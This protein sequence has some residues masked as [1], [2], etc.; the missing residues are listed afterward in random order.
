MAHVPESVRSR[1]WA[2]AKP[3][4]L[5]Q[6]V[7]STSGDLGDESR[8]HMLISV[9]R[10]LDAALAAGYVETDAEQAR[11]LLIEVFG[12]DAAKLR[13]AIFFDDPDDF[14][15]DEEVLKMLAGEE[16]LVYL[17]TGQ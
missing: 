2:A 6:W 10:A 17:E 16:R 11:R 8:T 13:G 3:V 1:A 14:I 5:Q 4:A 7:R 9:S 12:Y 15:P